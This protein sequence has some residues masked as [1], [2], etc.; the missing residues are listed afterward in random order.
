MGQN[1]VFKPI[2]PKDDPRSKEYFEQ[3]NNGPT[4]NG[5]A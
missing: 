3:V 4:F 2:I 1:G 5:K